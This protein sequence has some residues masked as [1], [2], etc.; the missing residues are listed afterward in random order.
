MGPRL[1]ERGKDVVQGQ[2]VF[3][4]VASMGP[5]LVERGKAI[6]SETRETGRH[7]SMGPRLVERGKVWEAIEEATSPEASMGPRLVERGKTWG[8]SGNFTYDSL[9]WGRAW[10]SAERPE[11]RA[12]FPEQ[13]ASFN[14][15]ALG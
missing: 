9:Q 15:A 10:L 14:G 6:S 4:W 3:E 1:V 7:A 12:E 13:P 8:S 5:R 11:V 2:V